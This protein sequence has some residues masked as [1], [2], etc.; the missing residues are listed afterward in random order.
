MKTA[1]KNKNESYKGAY[2]ITLY[3]V[4]LTTIFAYNLTSGK[5]RDYLVAV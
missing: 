3:P 1:R 4:A 5:Y 2:Y